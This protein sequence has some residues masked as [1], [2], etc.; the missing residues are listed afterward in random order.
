MLEQIE[1]PEISWIERTGFP[2]FRQPENVYCEECGKN[3]T[4]DDWYEDETHD[5][6]CKECLLFFHRKVD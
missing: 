4:D 5:F 2:S 1:H 6:M 3:I